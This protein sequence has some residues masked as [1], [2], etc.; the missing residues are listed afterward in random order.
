MRVIMTLIIELKLVDATIFHKT[1]TT[2]THFLTRIVLRFI[3]FLS[4][5]KM[6]INSKKGLCSAY[7]TL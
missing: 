4:L 7:Y 1:T 3:N 5:R 6:N 2:I